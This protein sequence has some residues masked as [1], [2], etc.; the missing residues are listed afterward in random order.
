MHAN[1]SSTAAWPSCLSRRSAPLACVLL[2]FATAACES[3]QRGGSARRAL[4]QPFL[5]ELRGQTDAAPTSHG[6][7]TMHTAVAAEE[8]PRSVWTA[9]EQAQTV[10]IE[11]DIRSDDE[12]GTDDVLSAS[13]IESMLLPPELRLDE[14]VPPHVWSAL[15]ELLPELRPEVLARV[16]PWAVSLMVQSRIVTDD[17]EA[18]DLVFTEAAANDGK[19]LVFLETFDEVG[20]ALDE[21]PLDESLDELI[22]LVEQRDSLQAAVDALADLYRSGDADAI[23]QAL[24][25]EGEAGA[26]REDELIL[27]DRNLNWLPAI[28]AQLARGGAFIAVGLGHWIGPFNLVDLLAQRGTV[29]SRVREEPEARNGTTSTRAALRAPTATTPTLPRRPR[30]RPAE[31]RRARQLERWLRSWEESS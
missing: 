15:V 13:V 5:W 30:L 20:G 18:M 8:L 24:F 16:Q 9:Y 14:L 3:E 2:L 22:A 23:R 28:E 7:G 11:S 17:V 19:N 29:A 21:L 27:R 12:G 25:S 10:V 6:F 1:G 4:E 31:R 26:S